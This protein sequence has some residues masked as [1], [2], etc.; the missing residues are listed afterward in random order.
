MIL[1]CDEK[2]GG[3]LAPLP[4]LVYTLAQLYYMFHWITYLL[5][6]QNAE[7]LP[8]ISRESGVNIIAGTS[9]YVHAFVPD[10]VKLLSVQEVSL[11]RCWM[12]E[13]MRFLL[14]CVM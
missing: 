5:V 9:Y 14:S 11:L 13:M 12:Y 6:L 8:R 4:P 3:T 10:D 7:E 2:T 1:H